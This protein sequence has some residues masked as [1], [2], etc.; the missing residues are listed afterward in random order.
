VVATRLGSLPELVRDGENGLLFEPGDVAGFASCIDALAGD[1]A[2][3]ARMGARARETLRR[4]YSEERH[5]E[6]L[7]ALFDAVTRRGAQAPR[8]PQEAP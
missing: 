1:A 3:R 7:L 6:L 5:C 2:L 8:L 4:D